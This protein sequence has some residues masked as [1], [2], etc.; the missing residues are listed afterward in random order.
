V[1]RNFFGQPDW[2]KDA[3]G[4]S[5]QRC[6][7]LQGIERLAT[8]LLDR[9]SA[10]CQMRLM[11]I[12]HPFVIGKRNHTE[13]CLGEFAVCQDVDEE[14]QEKTGGFVARF[15]L[16]DFGSECEPGIWERVLWWTD[17]A[18]P[19]RERLPMLMCYTPEGYFLGGLDRAARLYFG[20]GLTDVQPVKVALNGAAKAE[21]IERRT[22]CALGFD[23]E[24]QVWVGW[25]HRATCSF[26]IGH[27][28]AKGDCGAGNPKTPPGFEV[29]TLEDAK[30]CAIAFAQSVN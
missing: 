26:G 28:V 1:T 16:R 24:G 17:L 30:V 4:I 10:L 11:L 13:W 25:S 22:T 29:K 12:P 7:T 19:T 2:Y 18:I 9:L 6:T 20:W 3:H 15:E 23:P 8:G 27:V 5:H 21:A 14:T